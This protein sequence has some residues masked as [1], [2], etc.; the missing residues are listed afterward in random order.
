MQYAQNYL[1]NDYSGTVPSGRDL[2]T[3]KGQRCAQRHT[4][5]SDTKV[6]RLELLEPVVED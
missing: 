5:D 6:D 1:G 2:L 4:M 3:C